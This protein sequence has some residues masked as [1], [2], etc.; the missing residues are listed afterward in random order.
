M[1]ILRPALESC[2]LF[3][4][5]WRKASPPC[6]ARA[7]RSVYTDAAV[8]V[9]LGRVSKHMRMLRSSACSREFSSASA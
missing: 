9:A 5:T 3:A 1:K 4:K 2:L 8:G 6:V 7:P